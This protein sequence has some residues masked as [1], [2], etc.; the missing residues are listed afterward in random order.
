MKKKETL[1]LML[2][3][4]QIPRIYNEE[5]IVF[6]INGVWKTEYP[7]AKVWNQTLILYHTQKL[8]WNWLKTFNIRRENIKLLE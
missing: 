2:H 4:T 8:T 6:S 3:T 5:R 7:L 1:Q